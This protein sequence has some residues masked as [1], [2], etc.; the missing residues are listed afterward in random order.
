M[1]SYEIISEETVQLFIELEK[2]FKAL[3][4]WK[5][6]AGVKSKKPHV[7]SLLDSLDS[8][9]GQLWYLM[10]YIIL[11]EQKQLPEEE[12]MFEQFR[13]KLCDVYNCAQRIE[14]LLYQDIIEHDIY[15]ASFDEPAADPDAFH[16]LRF[17]RNVIFYEIF[18][19]LKYYMK[20]M[21]D[22]EVTKM[23]LRDVL[24]IMKTLPDSGPARDNV[25]N[26]I[27]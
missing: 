22:F 11:L 25:L 19:E 12:S 8:S 1:S 20:V 26:I 7:R 21:Q 2:S 6:Q 9:V 5:K 27:F 4:Q 16:D 15:I 10:K 13:V 17:K 14:D 18:T 3:F 24:N 23:K